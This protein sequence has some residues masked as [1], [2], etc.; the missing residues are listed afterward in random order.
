MKISDLCQICYPIIYDRGSE[1]E[2]HSKAEYNNI[3]KLNF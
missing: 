2:I 1:I 3:S